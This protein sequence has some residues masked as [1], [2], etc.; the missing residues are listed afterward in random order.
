MAKFTA[1]IKNGEGF[2]RCET[3]LF[4][5][6]QI[7]ATLVLWEKNK[8]LNYTIELTNDNIFDY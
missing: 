4:R 6:T 2:K 5:V 8:K 3:L 7:V 1:N